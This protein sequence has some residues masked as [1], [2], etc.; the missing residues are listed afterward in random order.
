MLVK[1][2]DYNVG[3]L[4]IKT[5]VMDLIVSYGTDRN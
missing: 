1:N 2:V 3:W 4:S 5:P